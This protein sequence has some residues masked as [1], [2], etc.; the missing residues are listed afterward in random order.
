MRLVGAI[1]FS[2]AMSPWVFSRVLYIYLTS[3]YITY[4]RLLLHT[5]LKHPDYRTDNSSV[6]FFIEKVVPHN[7][8]LPVIQ[9]LIPSVS[10]CSLELICLNVRLILIQ[11]RTLLSQ[12]IFVFHLCLKSP[13]VFFLTVDTVGSYRW[14]RVSEANCAAEAATTAKKPTRKDYGGQHRQCHGTSQSNW[15]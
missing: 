11:N 12:I 6:K 13:C 2:S 3:I 7:W 8:F 5:I 15:K 9:Y 10:Q 1:L 14:A 4:C